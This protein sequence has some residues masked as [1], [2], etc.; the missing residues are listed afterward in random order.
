MTPLPPNFVGERARTGALTY[1]V[2]REG[3]N[4]VGETAHAGA[5]TYEV[6]S[7]VEVGW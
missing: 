2:P 5:L 7:G 3:S 1:E 4:F 6:R